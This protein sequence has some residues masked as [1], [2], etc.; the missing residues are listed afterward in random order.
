M[1][2][3]TQKKFVRQARIGSFAMPHRSSW[4]S[5]TYLQQFSLSMSTI[6]QSMNVHTCVLIYSTR[7]ASIS[8][9]KSEAW[10]KDL[11][12]ATTCSIQIHVLVNSIKFSSSCVTR[13]FIYLQ[14]GTGITV[15]VLVI[16]SY[17]HDYSPTN[18]IKAF[19]SFH[20]TCTVP[21]EQ[22]LA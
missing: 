13:S 14:T 22:K 1:H 4:L 6:V 15:L 3:N 18:Q 5:L 8:I 17:F 9:Q 12:T 20:T 10:T 21:T 7:N 2:K 16:Y 19:H 11:N